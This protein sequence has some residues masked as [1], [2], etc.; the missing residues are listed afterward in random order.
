MESI[1]SFIAIGLST[2][3]TAISATW[4][5]AQKTG[6]KREDLTAIVNDVTSRIEKLIEKIDNLAQESVK[7]AEFQEEIHILRNKVTK[8]IENHDIHMSRHEI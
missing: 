5:I 4:V 7:R 8:H 6:L 1:A 2:L 3:F